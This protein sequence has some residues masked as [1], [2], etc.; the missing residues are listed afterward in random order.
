MVLTLALIQQYKHRGM[1]MNYKIKANYGN[2]DRD[3][4]FF[5]NDTFLTNGH[6]LVRR[7]CVK[8]S[9]RFCAPYDREQPDINKYMPESLDDC[10]PVEITRWLFDGGS[11][12]LRKLVCDG[13]DLWMDEEYFKCFFSVD[14]SIYYKDSIFFREDLSAFV[15]ACSNNQV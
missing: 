2:K 11:R 6:F 4:P 14:A 3:I 12:V 10:S 8:D 7:D 15:M 1:N 5:Y 9:F 13:V